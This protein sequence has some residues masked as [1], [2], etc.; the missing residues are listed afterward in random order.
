ML[1]SRARLCC[2]ASAHPFHLLPSSSLPGTATLILTCTC[3]HRHAPAHT[4]MLFNLKKCDY[5]QEPKASAGFR[6]GHCSFAHTTQLRTASA[7]L[8]SLW[9]PQFMPIYSQPDP[10]TPRHCT[11]GVSLLGVTRHPQPQ[12]TCPCPAC[13]PAPRCPAK[14]GKGRGCLARVPRVGWEVITRHDQ[15]GEKPGYA[16]KGGEMK[17]HYLLFTFISFLYFF[18]FF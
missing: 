4:I 6:A 13:S 5:L 10:F 3:T 16:R 8:L 7:P 9:Q 1:L 17:K 11:P 14:E 12:A 2:S 15:R 18:V